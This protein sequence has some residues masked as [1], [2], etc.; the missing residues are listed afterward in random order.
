M[1]FIINFFLE[2]K[3]VCIVTMKTVDD[4]LENEMVSLERIETFRGI[5]QSGKWLKDAKIRY[6]VRDAEGN[7][8]RFFSR[9]K[10]GMKYINRFLGVNVNIGNGIIVRVQKF[11]C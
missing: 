7:A 9:K 6:C 5:W 3:N 10:T 4:L 2:I 11:Y 8:I 1:Y